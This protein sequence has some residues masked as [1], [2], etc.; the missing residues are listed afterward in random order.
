MC[1]KITQSVKLKQ[2]TTWKGFTLISKW[3]NSN[4]VVFLTNPLSTFIF[5]KSELFLVCFN[6][7]FDL[8]RNFATFLA[9]N[10]QGKFI[11]SSFKNVY[12]CY[13]QRF[14]RYPESILKTYGSY[15]FSINIGFR[16]KKKTTIS[17]KYCDKIKQYMCILYI[18]NSD[19][20]LKIYCQLYHC[21]VLYYLWANNYFSS[22]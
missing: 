3:S 9:C 13:F 2:K 7:K 6:I 1:H 11:L 16:T 20:F 5:S 14:Q 8:I 21:Q 18:F 4:N 15:Y 17:L 10:L 12:S 19:C 22:K